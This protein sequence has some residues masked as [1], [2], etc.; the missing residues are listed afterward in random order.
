MEL[1]M[2]TDLDKALP[3]VIDFNFEE[4]KSELTERLDYYNHLVVTE[5][6]IQDGKTDRA[7]LR[8]L[9]EALET[10]RKEVKKQCEAPYKAF[11]AQVKELVALIDAPI[12]AID[13]QVKNFEQMQR[14]QKQSEI[15]TVYD[16]LVPDY[17]REILPLGRILDQKWLNKSTSMKSIREAIETRVKR[18]NV[19]MALIDGV[20]PQYMT[21]VRAK[22]IATLDVNLAMDERDKLMAAEQAFQQREAELA[23]YQSPVKEAPPVPVQEPVRPNPVPNVIPESDVNPVKQERLYLLKL[24]MHLTKN[25]ADHLKAF[26]SNEGISYRNITNEH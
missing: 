8:K 7:N 17:I 18:T 25:Q 14:D 24:E 19:D 9:R 4:L 20:Q 3:A 10:R 5:D 22:Y 16:E 21:A 26:L 11:E 12:A 23:A 13:C 2:T 15:E 1:R 6:A